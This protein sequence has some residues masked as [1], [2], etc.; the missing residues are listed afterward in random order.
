MAAK[1]FD[2][3]SKFIV[4][5]SYWLKGARV[6][7]FMEVGGLAIV[8]H[9]KFTPRSG[10]Y[11]HLTQSYFGI[12]DIG[13]HKYCQFEADWRWNDGEIEINYSTMKYTGKIL[14]MNL[15]EV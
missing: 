15:V 12:E 4:L 9:Q 5:G 11:D 13:T 8:Y 14:Q 10:M 2:K 3:H 7:E 6:M 1:K